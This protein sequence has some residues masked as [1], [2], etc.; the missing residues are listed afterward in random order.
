LF[1]QGEKVMVPD[2]QGWGYVEAEFLKAGDPD[3]GVAV[4]GSGTSWL[5]DVAWVRYEDGTT[6]KVPYARIRRPRT[7]SPQEMRT[8]LE[9]RLEEIEGLLRAI[10]Q[11]EEVVRVI[12]GAD[13]M[14]EL[15]DRVQALLQLT[16]PQAEHVLSVPV[17]RFSEGSRLSLIDERERHR[18]Y[19]ERLRH[20]G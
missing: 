20:D 1:E 10:E 13:G 5:V 16:E 4:K 6:D 2:P 15:R 9:D 7:L 18:A 19:L 17:A 3:E 14:D 11:R 8:L 12:A